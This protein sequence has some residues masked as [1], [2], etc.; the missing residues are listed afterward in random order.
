M[1]L[2]APQVITV[3]LQVV[4]MYAVEPFTLVTKRQSMVPP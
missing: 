4:P 2:P 3:P 1:V